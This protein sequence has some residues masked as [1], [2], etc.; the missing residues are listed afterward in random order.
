MGSGASGKGTS[1]AKTEQTANNLQTA[2][3]SGLALG[4]YSNNN[5]VDIQTSDPEVAKTAIAGNVV[6][7][8]QALNFAGHAADVA[9]EVNKSSIDSIESVA[10]YGIG[11]GNALAGKFLDSVSQTAAQN[12]GLLTSVGQNETDVALASQRASAQ[13]LD[14]SFQVSKS[15]A[16]QDPSYALQ[17]TLSKT[18]YIIVSLVVAAIGAVFLFRKKA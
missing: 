16:P 13:A 17:T 7:E 2:T 10:R 14:A 11:S 9:A 4:A 1:Q 6:A 12:I 8:G 18:A 3:T 5:K 15:V